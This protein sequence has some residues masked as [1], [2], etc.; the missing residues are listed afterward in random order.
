MLKDGGRFR[1]IYVMEELL[2][3]CGAWTEF[4][5]SKLI[6]MSHPAFVWET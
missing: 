3:S 6:K 4:L 1:G 5:V 2:R